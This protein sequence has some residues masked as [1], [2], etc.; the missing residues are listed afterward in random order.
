MFGYNITFINVNRVCTV[1]LR[2]GFL[3]SWVVVVMMMMHAE[4]DRVQVK[5]IRI[6]EVT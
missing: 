6:E 5:S 1:G 4:I 2:R 3:R